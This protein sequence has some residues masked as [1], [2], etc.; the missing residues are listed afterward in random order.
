[1]NRGQITLTTIGVMALT[2]LVSAVTTKIID[3]PT[4]TND[5]IEQIRKSDLAQDSMIDKICTYSINQTDRIDKNIIA[6]GKALKVDV[7]TGNE[8]ENPCQK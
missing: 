3:Y 8:K 7:V 2:A 6:I 1:M 4:K 5:E